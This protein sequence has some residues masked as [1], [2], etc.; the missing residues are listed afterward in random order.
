[1]KMR[2]GT[3]FIV[4]FVLVAGAILAATTLLRGQEALEIT[5]AAD[6]LVVDWVR[7]A[8]LDFNNSGATVGIGRRV[9][10]VVTTR[11]DASVLQQPWTAQDAAVG[12]IP[13]W[14]SLAASGRGSIVTAQTIVSSLARTPLVWMSYESRADDIPDVSWQGIQSAADSGNVDLA[15]SLPPNSVQ[16]L[17][18]LIS[19]VAEYHQTSILSD[20]NLSDP[21]MRAWLT[22]VIGSVPNFNTLG[23]NVAQYVAGPQGG[24][25]DAAIAPESQWMTTLDTLTRRGQPRFSYPSALVLFDFPFITLRS[26]TTTDDELSA[27]QSFAVFLNAPAQQANLER[28][29]LRPAQSEPL[30]DSPV[31]GPA[32]QYGIAAM[33][34]AV[35]PVQ[36]PSGSSIQAFLTWF[37]GVNR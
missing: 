31:F 30:P 13:A 15:F 29:G 6:P 35:Q 18:A 36:L 23:P 17:A 27:A 7:N 25:V 33:L 32:V 14:S 1:M 11:S 9:R 3:V 16:G 34:P 24:T 20:A 5:V 8:A 12:W 26:S 22:P 10:V 28:F 2:R 37:N 4:L 21:G 19:G